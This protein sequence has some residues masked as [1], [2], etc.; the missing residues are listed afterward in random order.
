M[1]A[2]VIIFVCKL[3][4]LR[5]LQPKPK[6]MR[7]SQLKFGI[8]LSMPFILLMGFSSCERINPNNSPR[9]EVAGDLALVTTEL[10]SILEYFDEAADQTTGK[11]APAYFKTQSFS[12]ETKILVLDSSYYDGD[13]VEFL[14]DFGPT[15]T[16]L[17]PTQKCLDG[18]FRGGVVKVM[19]ET[20]YIENTAKSHILVNDDNGFVVGTESKFLVISQ[21][22]VNIERK[23]RELL[24][25]EVKNLEI[26]N[27]SLDFDG[28]LS[29]EK[30]TGI[31]T[32]GVFGDHYLLTGNGTAELGDEEFKWDIGAPLK[33]KVEPG[34]G[35][36]P[37]QGLLNFTVE[38]SS[39]NITNSK[40][41]V[42]FDPFENESCDRI[43]RIVNAGK[44]TDIV[45]E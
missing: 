19:L 5:K 24:N 18:R 15:A 26:D 22:E 7:I 16:P 38:K 39:K 4:F 30:I 31:N 20:H 9:E 3:L 41:V 27:K 11:G 12:K 10:G 42:D 1:G 21:L 29:M 2:K 25:F 23:L 33:K 32:P 8:L 43:V 13:G 6:R 28:V 17:K 35:M 37:V 34:C 36:I 40:I 14:I 44:Q 45:L